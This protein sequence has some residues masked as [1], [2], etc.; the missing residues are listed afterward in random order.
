M[1]SDILIRDQ[2]SVAM[3]TSQQGHFG[4]VVNQQSKHQTVQ[5]SMGT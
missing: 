3:G 4:V 1:T 5:V 2:A